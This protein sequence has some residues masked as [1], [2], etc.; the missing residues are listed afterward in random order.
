MVKT[1]KLKN[2]VSWVFLVLAVILAPV[3][4]IAGSIDNVEDFLG[5]EGGEGES[6]GLEG[7]VDTSSLDE[8]QVPEQGTVVQFDD[9]SGWV[10][11]GT[12]DNYLDYIAEKEAAGRYLSSYCTS[13][14]CT[15][16]DLQPI[17]NDLDHEIGEGITERSLHTN[18]DGIGEDEDLPQRDI[19]DVC[20]EQP[21][22][23]PAGEDFVGDL[24]NRGFDVSF[25]NSM[26]VLVDGD[27]SDEELERA[28]EL[29]DSA[30]PEEFGGA[31]S[32][33]CQEDEE[34]CER[35][36]ER[37]QGCDDDEG[38][39]CGWQARGST[40]SDIRNSVHELEHSAYENA[41]T[42]E[43]YEENFRGEVTN[44]IRN[45]VDGDD[46]IDFP[47]SCEEGMM[48][49]CYS[50][51]RSECG[52]GGRSDEACDY[53]LEA[54]NAAALSDRGDI[55]DGWG[56]SDFAMEGLRG[57][58]DPDR[59]A[60]IFADTVFGTDRAAI[61]EPGDSNW[62]WVYYDLGDNLCLKK[63]SGY[64][65][66]LEEGFED[67]TDGGRTTYS[68]VHEDMYYDSIEGEMMGGDQISNPGTDCSNI[69]AD[70]RGVRTSITPANSTF[71][72]F[73]GYLANFLDSEVNYF[74]A[75]SYEY[76]VSPVEVGGQ[77]VG[78]GV[79]KQVIKVREPSSLS[80]DSND[81]FGG[82]V[83]TT[84]K[85]DEDVIIGD[86]FELHLRAYEGDIGS[87]EYESLDVDLIHQESGDNAYAEFV[88]DEDDEDDEDDDDD[89]EDDDDVDPPST[90]CSE[91][92]LEAC[93]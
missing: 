91:D 52:M 1:N 51:L 70:L 69:R 90:G 86:S 47:Q 67:D 75:L 83:E 48:N 38:V 60:L 56:A 28:Q 33:L 14:P 23:C 45:Y 80:G 77:T 58:V 35:A 17:T 34:S 49:Q 31:F 63:V 9:G 8:M 11:D 74:V 19:L 21:H 5:E 81:G 25:E 73:S 43:E 42:N 27:A 76:E 87:N 79:E 78:G 62:E 84:L 41:E 64:A 4:V 44:Q 18:Y 55:E 82:D 22:N 92:N 72:S 65:D 59:D 10:F 54:A 68:C 29:L 36:T 39:L 57:V 6:R 32:S 30:P 12:D 66:Y 53:A 20:T 3:I 37:L 40:R 71:L 50:D 24:N 26:E 88:P 46:D 7:E 16:D 13:D 93:I 2:I 89:D 15:A 61:V 85:H